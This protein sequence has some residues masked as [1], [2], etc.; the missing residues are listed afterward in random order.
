MWSQPNKM[1]RPLSRWQLIELTDSHICLP[2]EGPKERIA[3]PKK[4]DKSWILKHTGFGKSFIIWYHVPYNKD[5]QTT[6]PLRAFTS[7]SKSWGRSTRYAPLIRIRLHNNNVKVI[8]IKLSKNCNKIIKKRNAIGFQS[9]LDSAHSPPSPAS[10]LA[11][12]PSSAC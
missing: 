5:Q 7:R 9:T 11:N 2:A 3:N 4:A 8:R 1:E 10:P 6:L 12:L